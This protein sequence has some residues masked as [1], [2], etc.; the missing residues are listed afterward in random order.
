MLEAFAA[1]QRWMRA[2]PLFRTYASPMQDI[3][4]LYLNT[5]PHLGTLRLRTEDA[6]PIALSYLITPLLKYGKQ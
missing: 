5:T 2:H 1:E 3:F 4:N 6:V